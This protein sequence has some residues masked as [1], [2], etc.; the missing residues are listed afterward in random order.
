MLI[1]TF[2]CKTMRNSVD[3]GLL[4]HSI[5]L[6]PGLMHGGILAH[7]YG[8]VFFFFVAILSGNFQKN[9]MIC[10]TIIKGQLISKGH[11]GVFKSTKKTMKFL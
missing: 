3:D 8:E 6:Q 10:C 9:N 5:H 2:F 1:C 7:K 11:F 4:F